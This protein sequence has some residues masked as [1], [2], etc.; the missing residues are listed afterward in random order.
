MQS[1]QPSRNSLK[2]EAR[3]NLGF[4]IDSSDSLVDSHPKVTAFMNLIITTYGRNGNMKLVNSTDVSSLKSNLSIPLM[5]T[6]G[7]LDKVLRQAQEVMLLPNSSMSV[8][9]ARKVLVLLTDGSTRNLRT[10]E[11]PVDIADELR[12]YGFKIIVVGIGTS[13]DTREMAMVTGGSDKTFFVSQFD[14][15]VDDDFVKA[16]QL[17]TCLGM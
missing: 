15:L 8:Q 7:G 6:V 16:V 17:K 1:P 10:R 13:V 12:Q 11:D 9:G 5:H 3:I 2:C 14:D 4:I